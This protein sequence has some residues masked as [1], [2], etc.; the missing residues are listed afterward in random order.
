VTS[1]TIE[2]EALDEVYD[3]SFTVLDPTDP[4]NDKYYSSSESSDISGGSNITELIW[5]FTDDNTPNHS[6]LM[7]GYYKFTGPDDIYF[8]IDYQHCYSGCPDI[9]IECRYVTGEY[10][11]YWN[12][13]GTWEEITG[14]VLH[15]YDVTSETRD[16]SCF[17]VDIKLENEFHLET[18]GTTNQY[19]SIYV[20]NVSTSYNSPASVELDKESE[21]D[22]WP[23]DNIFTSVEQDVTHRFKTWE[24]TGINESVLLDDWFVDYEDEFIAKFYPAKSATGHIRID[25]V[26]T[27][28]SIKFKDP[29][30][31]DYPQSS[32]PSADQAFNTYSIPSAGYDFGSASGF[33]GLFLDMT[34]TSSDPYYVLQASE[35]VEWSSSSWIH[36]TPTTSPTAG[37]SIFRRFWSAPNSTDIIYRTPLR[38]GDEAS[39]YITKDIEFDVNN[40]DLIVDYKGHMLSSK[41]VSY[42]QSASALSPNSQRKIGYLEN[43]TAGVDSFIVVYESDTEVWMMMSETST[44]SWSWE[45]HLGSGVRPSLFTVEDSAYITWLNGEDVIVGKYH[46]GQFTSFDATLI[47][48]A[49][50]DASP[51]IAHT[52]DLTTIVYEKDNSTHLAYVVFQCSDLLEEGAI[53]P[54]STSGDACETPTMTAD[55]GTLFWVAWREAFDIASARINV[56]TYQQ[57]VDVLIEQK[58][59][60][61]RYN[62]YYVGA[63]S[64]ANYHSTQ[65]APNN[66]YRV[67]A[68]PARDSRLNSKINVIAHNSTSQ[69]SNMQ[70]IFSTYTVTDIWA[71]SVSS[72]DVTP[73]SGSFDNVMCAFNATRLDVYPTA[74]ETRVLKLSCGTWSTTSP[75]V[76]DAIH[77]SLVAYPPSNMGRGVYIDL[78]ENNIPSTLASSLCELRTTNSSLSKTASVPLSAA[79]VLW[80]SVDTTHVGLG[81]GRMEIQDNGTTTEL[82]WSTA[83]SVEPLVVSNGASNYIVSE[84]FS[85]PS[86]AVLK[87]ALLQDKEGSQS[88]PVGSQITVELVDAATN[89]V[90]RTV[91]TIGVATV[92]NGSSKTN[93]NTN[94]GSFNG[95]NLYIRFSVS[96]VTNAASLSIAD[97]Y[98]ID[99]NSTEAF[100]KAES[101]IAAESNP[102]IPHQPQLAQNYPNPFNPTTTIAIGVPECGTVT[103]AIYDLNGKVVKEVFSGHVEAGWHSHQVDMSTLPSGVYHYSLQY[104]GGI[105]TRKMTLTK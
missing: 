13:L 71:P 50:D 42:G 101:E 41:A 75:Q 103:L 30:K 90:V 10:R 97:Y 83:P 40:A 25:G 65:S 15:L 36:M 62:D 69:W 60:I 67:L 9:L 48:D 37:E 59:Y 7:Y 4:D 23:N 56:R 16:V 52:G 22:F 20:D 57:P 51:V 29:W 58:R 91:S 95:M 21:H 8:Y 92:S 18:G 27:S 61:P 49:A 14:D 96:G 66:V 6:N 11:Y 24:G 53:S 38:S 70:S 35:N 105:L 81:L 64:I 12:D 76:S 2:A 63:P 32:P 87:L 17:Q 68:A 3:T 72:V 45:V 31:T 104:N 80:I 78:Q 46:N 28:G 33:G 19:G 43:T 84:T 100:P 77:P 54:V 1:V 82:G 102:A 47:H 88:L 89:R 74:Y 44:I 93:V 98:N 94:L 79:R 73:C 39:G 34:P 85:V 99:P 55:D 26:N 86:N 5:D